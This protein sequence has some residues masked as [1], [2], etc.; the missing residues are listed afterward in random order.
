MPQENNMEINGKL[1]KKARLDIGLS[2]EE[3][4]N[5]I[6][7]SRWTIMDSEREVTEPGYKLV[8]KWLHVC[9]YGVTKKTA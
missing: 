4:A 6:G 7:C 2:Q 3:L 5:K 1:L 8:M 9:G